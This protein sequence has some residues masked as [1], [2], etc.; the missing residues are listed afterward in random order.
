MGS[1][2]IAVAQALSVY[3][4]ELTSGDL[5]RSGFFQEAALDDDRFRYQGQY[6]GAKASVPGSRFFNSER[7]SLSFGP[8]AGLVIGVSIGSQSARAAIFD[9]GG[10][11]HHPVELPALDN[12]LREPPATVLDRIKTAAD[13]VLG[14]ALSDSNLLLVN[15]ALPFLG[16]SVAWPT[17]LNRAKLPVGNALSHP[18]W[19][20]SQ[21]LTEQVA[22]H[23]SLEDG[24]SHAINDAAAA[25]LAMAHVQTTQVEHRSQTYPILTL[26]LRIAGGIG[27]ASIVIEPPTRAHELHGTSSGFSRSTLIGGLDHHA[28]EIGHVPIARSTLSE[29]NRRRGELARLRPFRC[30]C[31][32]RG[33]PIP[34]HLEAVAAVP[35]TTNRLDPRR[36]HQKV[37]EHLLGDINHRPH[38]QILRDV[39]ALVGETLLNPVA[40]LNPGRINLTGSLAVEPVQAEIVDTIRRNH[41]FSSQ[42]KVVL[43]SS[44]ES[45]FS[46]AKGAALAVLRHRVHRRLPLLLGGKPA[47]V[48]ANVVAL[49]TPV[50]RPPWE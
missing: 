29:I 32:V 14:Q 19:N 35:A 3:G 31:T 21:P 11:M 39:G 23:L 45:A 7:S 25:A 44:T 33:E 46:P 2:L 42:P 6:V 12:Q 22:Q 9:A 16:L 47:T 34:M 36:P 48:R 40:M 49:T 50:R 18:G 26:T 43:P 41:R 20:R 8:G 30:S 1:E 13:I 10:L 24:H 4:R 27:A 38:R 5:S 17:P 15:G 28:G 37:L